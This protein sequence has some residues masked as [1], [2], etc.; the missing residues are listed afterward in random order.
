MKIK[1]MAG[2]MARVHGISKQTLLEL[3]V[4]V[5]RRQP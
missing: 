2:E 3:Q 1:F 4:P 5:K